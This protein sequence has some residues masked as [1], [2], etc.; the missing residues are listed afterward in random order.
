MG[1]ARFDRAYS[2]GRLLAATEAVEEALQIKTTQSPDLSM[3][4]LTDIQRALIRAIAQSFPDPQ[5]FTIKELARV[6]GRDYSSVH[7]LLGSI[8]IK[9]DLPDRASVARYVIAHKD[10]VLTPT[11]DPEPTH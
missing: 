8:A 1:F 5:A 7:E 4:R 9:W 6:L 3:A 10:R 2:S 11:D